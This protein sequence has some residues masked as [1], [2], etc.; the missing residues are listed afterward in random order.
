MMDT[1]MELTRKNF[2]V[3]I[4]NSV[5]MSIFHSRPKCMCKNDT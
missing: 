4:F 5:S 3:E 2:F 1:F